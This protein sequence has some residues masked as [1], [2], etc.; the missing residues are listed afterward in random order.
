MGTTCTACG[1]VNRDSARFCFGC[2]VRLAARCATCDAELVD[3][4][5]FCDECGAPTDA[6]PPET[7]APP[8]S[9]RKTVTVVFADLHGSTALHERMDPESARAVMSGFYDSMRSVVDAHGGRVVKFV[10]DGVMAVFG[11]PDVGED[12]AARA[13]DAA[14]AMVAALQG[15]D[16]TLSLRVGVNTGEVVVAADDSDVVGDVVNVAARLESN[17]PLNGVLVGESTWRLTREHAT[18]GDVEE[19]AVKNRREPVRA[20]RL[21]GTTASASVGIRFVGRDVEMHQLSAVFDHAVASDSVQLA[22]VIGSPGVGKSRLLT[23]LIDDLQQRAVVLVARCDANRTTYAPMVDIVRAAADAAGGLDRLVASDPDGSRLSAAIEELLEHG[24]ASSPEETLWAVRRALVGL[25]TA[26]ARPVVVVL[27]DVHWAD[28][29]LLDLVEHLAEWLRDAP[30]LLV[31]AARPELRELRPALVEPGG[32]QAIALALEGLDDSATTMLARELLGE[33]AGALPV[34][35]VARLVDATGGNPLFV[36]ELLRMLIDDGVLQHDG[37]EGWRLTVDADLVE[38]PPTISAL[39]G[40][41]IDRLSVDERVVLERAAVIGREVYRGLL[42]ELLPAPVRRNVAVTLESLRRKE[43]LEP[44]GAYWIDEPVLRFHHALIR[45][46]AYRRLLKEARAELHERVAGWLTDKVGGA[47]EYDE[48]IGFHLEHAFHNRRQLERVDDATR[49]LAAEAALRLGRAGRRALEHDDLPAAATLTDRALACVE[50]NDPTRGDLLI[51]RCEALLGVGDVGAASAA[52]DALLSLGDTSSR[53]AAWATCF[54]AQRVTLRGGRVAD[55]EQRL[56]DA[57]ATLHSLGD[58]SGAAKAHRVHA[59][60]LARLGQIGACEAALDRALTAARDANSRRQITNVLAAAPVAALWGPSPV[61]RAGGRCL[62]VVRLLRITTGAPEVEA[63]STRC[64]AVLEALRGRFDAARSL[65]ASARRILE[66]RGSVHALLE[67]DVACGI[68]ELYAG[69]LAEAASALDRAGAGLRA[70]GAEA[71]AQR[72]IALRARVAFAADDIALALDLANE[73]AASEDDLTTAVAA[74]TVKAQ[75]LARRGEVDAALDLGRTT[76]ELVARTDLLVDH[77]DALAAVADVLDASGDRLAAQDARRRAAE[78]YVQ[79]GATA[80]AERLADGAPASPA[81]SASVSSSDRRLENEMTRLHTAITDALLRGEVDPTWVLNENYTYDDR[82]V[83]L[84]IALSAGEDAVAQLRLIADVGL[85]AVDHDVIAIRGDHC[86]LV[87]DTYHIGGSVVELLT[88]LCMHPGGGGTTIIFDTQALL[89]ALAELDRL[90]G[91]SLPSG[92]A[93]TLHGLT[94]FTAAFNARSD[95]MFELMAPDL[96]VIDRRSTTAFD[97]DRA[98]T[99]V[100]MDIAE[101]TGQIFYAMELLALDD[102][103]VLAR[104]RSVETNPAG[105]SIEQEMVNVC[106]VHDG[107][108]SLVEMFSPGD[109]SAAFERFAE[110]K[111]PAALG[112]AATRNLVRGCEAMSRG[113]NA[114][115]L[116]YA[117]P[118]HVFEDHTSGMTRAASDDFEQR[119]LVPHGQF[120]PTPLAVRGERLSLAM[121]RVTD[122]DTAFE[123]D[124]LILIEVDDEERTLATLQFDPD[125]LPGAI[126][127]LERRHQSSLPPDVAHTMGLLTTFNQAAIAGDADT[128]A[129]L[130]SEDF[131]VADRRTAGFGVLDRATTL[132]AFPV[133][134]EHQQTIFTESLLAYDEHGCVC[135]TRGF[136]VSDLGNPYEQALLILV[137]VHE[138]KVARMEY[139]DLDDTDGA[140]ARYRELTAPVALR[141][142]A[143]DQHDRWAR[144]FE[145]RR[146]DDIAAMQA[147]DDVFIDR[148]SVVGGKVH[149]DAG[150]TADMMRDMAASGTFQV[151]TEVMAIRGDELALTRD[152]YRG[153]AFETQILQITRLDEASRFV[154]GMV[155]DPDDLAGAIQE[156]EGLRREQVPPS[157]A[158][159][160]ELLARATRLFNQA[161]V[162]GF[163]SLIT[164]DFRVVDHNLLGFGDF[165]HSAAVAGVGALEPT[166][167]VLF[168]ENVLVA[169]EHGCVAMMRELGPNESGGTVEQRSVAVSFVRDGKLALIEYFPPG[170]VEAALARYAELTGPVAA[171]DNAAVRSVRRG[172]E[173]MAAG[174]IEGM[175]SLAMPDF[176]V[177]DRRKGLAIELEGSATLSEYAAPMLHGSYEL[178]VLHIRGDRLALVRVTQAASESGFTGISL[179]INEVNE[180]GVGVANVLF[181]EDDLDAALGELDRRHRRMLENAAFRNLET[182]IGMIGRREFDRPDG[183]TSPHFVFE[184][185]RA[186]SQVRI[187]GWETI[188]DALDAM[189]LGPIE[190]E[191]LE[192]R[193]DRLVLVRETYR[194]HDSD[195]VETILVLHEVDGFGLATTDMQFDEDDLASA[196]EELD[197]RHA[198]ILE[199]AAA[200]NVRR[201]TDAVVRGDFEAIAAMAV[202]DFLYED[203]RKGIAFEYVGEKPALEYSTMMAGSTFEVEVMATRGDNLALVRVV[204]LS[205]DGYSGGSL[206]INQ[207][208]DDGVGV[209]NI[210]FDEDDLASALAELDRLYAASL[211]IPPIRNMRTTL[212]AMAAGDLDAITPYAAPNFVTTDRRRGLG[213]EFA[214]VEDLAAYTGGLAGAR[215]DLEVI[216]VRGQHLA[217]LRVTSWDEVRGYVGTGINVVETN[218]DGL[219][220]ATVVFDED[221]LASAV[222][223]FERRAAAE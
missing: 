188:R 169:D 116:A 127:E 71:D 118:E 204:E 13:V 210:T 154:L 109:E 6:A 51:D 129:R 35:L 3:G 73:C 160:M 54:D 42:S 214:G 19:L 156:L 207:V 128:F 122:P 21:L 79:K 170:D 8:D 91:R 168:G 87:K 34:M 177:D 89:D 55:L 29:L 9:A 78:L 22:A 201:G 20:Y 104:M 212:E 121:V 86:A 14:L 120:T 139:L 1:E 218:D 92:E 47:E 53:L 208:N 219:T 59:S 18:F 180:C 101:E 144:A 84:G 66:E 192:V 148:R 58:R 65:I 57:A 223:E 11:V 147:A 150:A 102:T 203:R 70:L 85:D 98:T 33:G 12:D 172:A 112:N 135:R 60:V 199:N 165:D 100:W 64:Q 50:P 171:V 138:G 68:V 166:G 183:I 126:A 125:D 93:A 37:D 189:A 195:Y 15:F 81:S 94:K 96:R 153:A 105:G 83:G 28:E 48:L 45:D 164:P 143:T 186:L 194:E 115:L 132:T 181:D 182:S 152:I 140:L 211:D 97:L 157:V 221:D 200:R 69:E 190:L 72:A 4:A 52:I 196:R 26:S 162:D 163:L 16:P 155:F 175:R 90:Y 184:S 39:L 74:W 193:G 205:A 77:A 222:E 124:N 80:L 61:P 25:S 217:L 159:T 30:I 202:P 117:A 82:R 44:A 36:R 107:V 130:L 149:L 7:P 215:F 123:Q 113:D 110:L 191:P 137:L 136:E 178:D 206:N 176:V 62:D 88:L 216:A 63:I 31:I 75:V 99:T 213:V 108:L 133:S 43:L 103:A 49:V 151:V 67:L 179:V 17:A 167:V 220:V 131:V 76:V 134:L 158:A 209:A 161:D 119:V 95:A 56:T 10:G 111:S 141:N 40:A 187:E 173:L 114:A 197:R 198:L 32:R 142:R 106:V 27:D 24:R 185:R 2:G 5:K 146:W 145:D 174:D 23:E 41:R 38:V 46:A